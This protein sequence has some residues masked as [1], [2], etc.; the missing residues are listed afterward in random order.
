M[1]AHSRITGRGGL[2]AVLLGIALGT[3]CVH[4]AFT[5]ATTMKLAARPA[6]CYLDLILHG[7]PPFPY[8]VIGHVST[9]STAGGWF[10]IGEN[11][12]VA[13]ERLQDEACSA[14]AHG[15][16]QPDSQAQGVWTQNGY[17]KS[18]TGTAVAFVYVDPSGR[19]LPP[20]TGPRLIIHPGG[21]SGPTP[22]APLLT[23][24]PPLTPPPT[25]VAPSTP[26]S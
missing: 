25:A 24:S 13:M 15:L 7:E 8:V 11:N 10:A 26:P 16:I 4:N 21:V 1:T 2:L 3:G 9:E 5:P 17:S 20:P 12:E 22:P 23:P 6:G 14:G 19:A 18:T